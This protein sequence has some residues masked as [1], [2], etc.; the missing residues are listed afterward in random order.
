M[1]TGWLDP[2]QELRKCAPS[3]DRRHIRGSETSSVSLLR[4]RLHWITLNS[5]CLSLPPGA[6]LGKQLP[7]PW[8]AKNT[9]AVGRWEGKN[10]ASARL[11]A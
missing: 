5:K 11:D 8:L 4:S 2:R 10:R 3:L 7:Y 9:S 1:R 6:V